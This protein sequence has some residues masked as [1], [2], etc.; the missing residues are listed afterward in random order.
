MFYTLEPLL[1]TFYSGHTFGSVVNNLKHCVW[2]HLMVGDLRLRL[3][4]GRSR[5]MVGRRGRGRGVVGRRCRSRCITRE[6]LHYSIT[7]VVVNQ[8]VREYFENSRL[9]FFCPGLTPL[10]RC[11]GHC[12]CSHRCQG[13]HWRGFHTFKDD[14]D[15]YRNLMVINSGNV[16]QPSQLMFNE[17]WWWVSMK[18]VRWIDVTRSGMCLA[19][20][21]RGRSGRSES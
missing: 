21:L 15:D 9:M 4:I 11:S 16:P 20:R 17:Y 5:R 10:R 6:R 14:D 13:T 7:V 8:L 19:C 3:V 1:A 12:F 2:G 18:C